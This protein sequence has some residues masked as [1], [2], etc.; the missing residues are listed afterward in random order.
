MKTKSFKEILSIIDQ[1]QFIVIDKV[2]LSYYP[3]IE[4][5]LSH[6]SVYYLENPELSKTHLGFIQVC[7]FFLEKGIKRNDTLLA[8]GGGATSD[9]A[10]FVA[11]SLLRGISWSVIPTTLL[12]MIDASIG[13]KVGI[14]TE[15]GKNL[16]G[17]FH[18]PNEIY[19]NQKFLETLPKL[20]LDSGLGEL[21][22]YAFLNTSVYKTILEKGFHRDLIELCAKT[23]NIIA[24][25]DFKESGQRKVLNL[26]HTFGH[27]I[28]KCL[29]I[30]H[31][32]AVYY[33]IEMILKF[34]DL[35]L[36]NNFNLLSKK[37]FINLAP[38]EKMNFDKFLELV[39]F[40][41][42]KTKEGKI[43]LI[44]PKNIEEIDI[45]P[46]TIEEI[47][48]RLKNHECYSNYFL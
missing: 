17:A 3:E 13:G 32:V 18:K 2:L 19:L 48:K 9:L 44:L 1:H 35:N 43:E 34:F 45:K 31:G 25:S 4:K 33:G 41:K 23:K 16:I 40:D 46:F 38:L 8:I 14:N 36:T 22:K 26:G 29:E 5:V 30:P 24:E 20:E 10:G 42:K 39:S 27:G 11:A 7:N 37:M 47:R 21:V 6:K 28:E 12:S 15:F